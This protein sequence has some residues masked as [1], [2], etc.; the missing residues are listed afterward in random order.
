MYRPFLLLLEFLSLDKVLPDNL[1]LGILCTT[2]CCV[3]DAGGNV[4]AFLNSCRL[5]TELL[6]LDKLT[7]V[8]FPPS[9]RELC[10]DFFIII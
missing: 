1:A 5:V 8:P 10:E 6:S 4:E 3:E 2:A 9:R 7:L